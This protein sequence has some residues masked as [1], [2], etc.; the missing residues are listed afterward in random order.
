[1]SNSSFIGAT[2]EKELTRLGVCH[3]FKFVISS[4]DY[5]VRKPDPIIFEVALRRLGLDPARVWFAGDNVG[6]D[7]V[8]GRGA[9]M[10]CVAFNPRTEIPP[11]LGGHTLITRW[12]ELPSLIS[13]ADVA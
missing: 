12:S 1:V 6:Y 9:G 3:Y 2:L 4:A 5:G 13:S 10:F 11:D 7:I 8:G